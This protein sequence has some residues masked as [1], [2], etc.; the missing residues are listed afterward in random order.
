MAD[1]PAKPR[2]GSRTSAAQAI[3]EIDSHELL[4]A[5][6]RVLIRHAGQVY[7]LRETRFGKLIL[8]K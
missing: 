8:T 4:G 2:Q 1:T 7:E 3:P 5:D 6:R